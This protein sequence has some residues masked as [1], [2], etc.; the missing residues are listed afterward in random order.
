MQRRAFR[1]LPP[2]PGS[3]RSL[4]SRRTQARI[5]TSHF[6]TVPTFRPYNPIVEVNP[7]T[8]GCLA[9]S[10]TILVK[11]WSLISSSY[12]LQRHAKDS[13]HLSDV[14]TDFLTPRLLPLRAY[15][16]QLP[17]CSCLAAAPRAGRA[18]PARLFI[19]TT[20]PYH[21][22]NPGAAVDLAWLAVPFNLSTTFL[23]FLSF[24]WIIPLCFLRL[25][26]SLHDPHPPLKLHTAERLLEYMCSAPA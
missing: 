11:L 23:S 13:R 16:A 19:T 25:R 17:R 4:G 2:F 6:L 3:S 24:L 12:V 9:T 10:S 1:M 21:F 20:C 5:L 14:S 8:A 26:F 22:A 15:L 7:P 18:P